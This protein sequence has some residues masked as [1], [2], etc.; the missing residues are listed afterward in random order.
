MADAQVTVVDQQIVVTP[1]GY[2]L[3][4]PLVAAVKEAAEQ[5][6]A[7]VIAA[8][9]ILDDVETEGAAQ[10]ALINAAGLAGQR[11][12][13][14]ISAVKAAA[15]DQSKIKLLVTKD[16]AKTYRVGA[17]TEIETLVPLIGPGTLVQPAFTWDGT[18]G[19]VGAAR[20]P[21]ETATGIRFDS[22]T[23][24]DLASGVLSQTGN[25][26]IDLFFETPALTTTAAAPAGTYASI[27]AMNADIANLKM[28]DIVK[29]VGGPVTTLTPD[30]P[31]AYV[32]SME[33]SDAELARGLYIKGNGTMGRMDSAALFWILDTASTPTKYIRTFFDRRGQLIMASYDG[34]AQ[35]FCRTLSQDVFTPGQSRIQHIKLEVDTED[36]HARLW[37]NGIEVSPTIGLPNFVPNRLYVNGAPAGNATIPFSGMR[38]TMNALCVTENLDFSERRRVSDALARSFGTPDQAWSQFVNV[39]VQNGQSRGAGTVDASGWPNTPDVFSGWNGEI[40][41]SVSTSS[42]AY[43]PSQVPLKRVYAQTSPDNPWDNGPCAVLPNIFGN[44]NQTGSYTCSGAAGETNEWGIFAQLFKYEEAR[45]TDWQIIGL[46]YGGHSLGILDTKSNPNKYLYGLRTA[47]GLTNAVPRDMINRQVAEAVAFWRRRGQ[48]CRLVM[49]YHEQGETPAPLPIDPTTGNPFIAGTQYG[50]AYE[51]SARNWINNELLKLMPPSDGLQPIYI[52]KAI[53]FSTDGFSNAFMGPPYYYDDQLR[54]LEEHRDTAFRYAFLGESYAVGGR[55]IHWPTINYRCLGE[56]LGWHAG[57]MIFGGDEGRC[58]QALSASIVG[59]K[60]RLFLS[61]AAAV[62][63]AAANSKPTVLY[64]LTTGGVDT[65]GLVFEPVSGGRTITAVD[66]SQIAAATP[67]IEVTISG[68]GAIAGDRINITGTN[69]RWSN[70]RRATRVFGELLDQDWTVPNDQ[71]GLSGGPGAKKFKV[72][73]NPYEITPWLAAGSYVL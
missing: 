24:F 72:S 71:N 58:F 50:A 10:L 1:F 5:T 73:A 21:V 16:G 45:Q 59:G 2:D 32:G 37:L 49:V 26:Q 34:A 31:A 48:T 56:R 53:N 54:R 33:C 23:G 38:W 52:K 18:G 20:R 22:Q 62:V 66:N 42:E 40:I 44:P 39:I 46:N 36:R 13:R 64:R 12:E 4:A 51:Y 63:D 29:V 8:G 19:A 35:A 67:Y 57:R 60:I 43:Y 69:A 47:P 41:K 30:V 3:L 70:Y 61:E 65:F 17:P 11:A 6:A 14:L 7:D 28:G 27:A 68:G 25:Y 55:F 15:R 9:E